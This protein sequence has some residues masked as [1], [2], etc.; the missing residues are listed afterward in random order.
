LT[1]YTIGVIGGSG[2]YEMDGLEVNEERVVETPFGSPSDALLLGTLG[3]RKVAFLSRHGRGHRL[4]PS[5]LNFR[6]NV[7][8]L[9][10]VGVCRVIGVSAVG[11]MQERYEPTHIV[12][13]DQFIDRTR[14]RPDTFFGNGLVAHIGFSDPICGELAA[15]V[16]TAASAEGATA[17]RGGTYLCMEGPQFS[18]RA[19]SELYRQ[20]GVA[21]IGMT[22]LQ[23]A[24]LAREAEMCFSTL[25]M[26]TDYDCWHES[27]DAVTA[28]AVI[29]V[30]SQNVATA[31]RVVRRLIAGIDEAP[32]CSCHRALD[33]AVMTDINNVPASTLEALA[34]LL[35]RY[36]DD[37]G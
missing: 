35:A 25:A 27:E 16:A 14:H 30:L 22:N 10:S 12:V 34:P 9:K 37:R 7:W 24:K 11:S 28:E 23:E 1:D 8:A 21:V 32:S 15:R 18:T 26:V 2:L 33:S 19:E 20:W 13:P 17:H 5:E 36:L 4:L 6:A 29:A 3:G 31:T